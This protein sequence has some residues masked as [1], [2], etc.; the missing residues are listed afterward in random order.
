MKKILLTL[1][2]TIA[3]LDIADVLAS[4]LEE[5]QYELKIGSG[6]KKGINPNGTKAFLFKYKVPKLQPESA[7]D[8]SQWLHRGG[9]HYVAAFAGPNLPA[10]K[11]FPLE[12]LLTSLHP[13]T[14]DADTEEARKCA[15]VKEFLDQQFGTMSPLQFLKMAERLFSWEAC[16]ASTLQS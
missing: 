13:T 15:E 1:L 8:L 16:K 4:N 7:N 5:I 3:S 9:G 6:P 14:D 10:S 2:F 12:H 11:D